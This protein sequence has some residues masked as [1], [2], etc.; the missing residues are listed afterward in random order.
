MWVLGTEP[1]QSQP[2]ALNYWG[3]SAAL[4]VSPIHG[5]SGHLPA[6][7]PGVLL[8]KVPYCSKVQR[9]IVLVADGV[10]EML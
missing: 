4:L 3:L 6:G 7:L 1:L 2:R 9:S 10:Q 5:E 8:I